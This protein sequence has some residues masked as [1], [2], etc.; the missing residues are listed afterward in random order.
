MQKQRQQWA[1]LIKRCEE[2]I[3]AREFTPI[4]YEL[5]QLDKTT[6]N[7][8]IPILNANQEGNQNKIPLHLHLKEEEGTLV[9]PVTSAN[10][11]KLLDNPLKNG[12]KNYDVSVYISL[13]LQLSSV[14]MK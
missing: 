3:A 1:K 7:T 2:D 9:K 8:Q 14:N 4:N 13:Q 6:E 12:N 10:Q 5:V 11:V